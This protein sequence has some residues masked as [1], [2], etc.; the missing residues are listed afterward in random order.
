MA[1]HLALKQENIIQ[2]DVF[3]CLFCYRGGGGYAIVINPIYANMILDYL[4]T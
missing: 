4:I 3:V 1:R 2:H